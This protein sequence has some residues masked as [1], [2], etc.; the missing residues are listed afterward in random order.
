MFHNVTSTGLFD[1]SVSVCYM[2]VRTIVLSRHRCS[3]AR[4]VIIHDIIHGLIYVPSTPCC[5]FFGGPRRGSVRYS[6]RSIFRQVYIPTGLYS[7]RSIFRQVVFPTGLHSDRLIIRQVVIPTG[8]Y[9]DRSIFRQVYIPTS[10]YSDKSLFRQF[11]D[12]N[13][14]G[15]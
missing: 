8:L 2:A 1:I 13:C 11:L 10:R 3:L 4:P 14:N 5:G 9:S 6:D 12:V 7:D 15:N